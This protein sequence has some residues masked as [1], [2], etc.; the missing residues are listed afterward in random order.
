M[1]RKVFVVC[2]ALFVL[3][4]VNFV[5][6][7][8]RQ[9]SNLSSVEEVYSISLENIDFSNEITGMLNEGVINEI[10][11]YEDVF[12]ETLSCDNYSNSVLRWGISRRGY[13]ETPQADPGAPELLKKYG[14][15]YLGDTSSNKI[16]LTFDEGYENGY[17]P[18]ILDVLKDNN[19]KAMF[20]ITGPYLK[21][22]EDLVKRMVEEG[23]V[24]GNHT[25]H[26]PSLPSLDNKKIEDEILGLEDAFSKIFGKKMKYLRPPKG[27]YS[28]RTLAVTQKLGYTNL[29][30]SFAYDDW[31][32]DKVRGA[33]YAYEKVINNLHN[34]AVIL[35]HA[36]SKDNADALDSIIKGAREKGFEFGDVN[37]L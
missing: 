9:K 34:G 22:H 27:E 17:T 4:A 6:R 11:Q 15:V 37:D 21:E 29:F 10:P 16:Y 35:L 8:Y 36:V 7:N 19:V 25:V 2:I 1:K 18:K 3:L 20:F 12:V 14:G 31:Y 33:D 26:H 30:W 13:N 28:E 5:S 24:V 32:R 23:H